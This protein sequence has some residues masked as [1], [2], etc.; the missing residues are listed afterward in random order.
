[1]KKKLLFFISLLFISL[2]FTKNT[3]AYGMSDYINRPLCG[4][5]EVALFKSDGTIETKSCHSTF[6][7]ADAAMIADGN[8]DLA[9]LARFGSETK[10][11][12]AN[13]ALVDLTHPADTFDIY[14]SSSIT[15]AHTYMYGQGGY[16]GAD[17]AFLGTGYSF[18]ANTFTFKIKI[19]GY[20]G[21]V[22]SGIV[23]IVPLVWVNSSSSY[24]ISNETIRHNYVSK[25]QNS[26]SSSSGNTIGPKP[27][28]IP[29]GT[30]YSY[31]G[32]YFY[33]DRYAMI[34]DYKGNTY[35]NSINKDNPY[36][37]YYQ[38]LSNRTRTNYSSINIDEYIRNMGYGRDVYGISA[39]S[40]DGIA[41]SR[42]YGMG[43]FFYNAQER[44]GVN[45]LLALGVSRNETGNGK[46]NLAINKNNGFGLNAVDSSPTES[47]KW[48]ATFS[49]SILGY[50]NKWVNNGYA[51]PTDLRYNGAQYG[52]KAVGMNVQYA[53]DVYWGEKMASNY[54]YMDKALGLQDY[55]YYQLG[56][57]TTSTQAMQQPNYSSKSMYTYK[58][59]DYGV[60]IVGEVEGQEVNG[61]KTW[62]KVV[63]DRNFDNNYNILSLGANYN[64]NAYVYVPAAYILKINEGKNGYITPNEV[65]EYQD[66]D[67]TYDLYI[68]DTVLKPKVAISTKETL[69]YY[70][71]TLLSAK[72]QTLLKNRYVMVFATAYDGTKNPVAYLVTSDYKYNQK[73]WV[74]TDAIKF[75]TCKYGQAHVSVSSGVNT[76]T[77]INPDTVDKLS[78]HFSGL[79]HYNYVPILEE[80]TV[81]NKLWYKVPV[82]LS[83]T[84]R[85]FGWTLADARTADEDVYISAYQYTTANTDPVI[86]ASNQELV[87]GTTFNPKD[88]ATA[89]D[90][91]DGNLTSNIEV[92]TNNVNT[93]IPGQYTVTYKVTDK[94]NSSVTKTI[95]ITII[96]DEEPIITAEDI[97]III[98]TKKDLLENVTASDKEDGT[99]TNITVDDSKV[100]YEAVGEYTITYQVTDK[101]GHIVTKDVKLIIKQTEPPIITASDKTITIGVDFNP[102]EGVTAKSSDQTDLTA[103]IKVIKNTVDT[104][105]KGTYEVT[106]EVTD[107]YNN[108]TTKTIQVTVIDKEAK[109][110]LYYFD[111]LKEESG[112]LQIKGYH[113][114]KGINHQLDEEFNFYIILDN[115]QT[116]TKYRQKMERITDKSEITRPVYSTDGKDYTY[117]WFK[118]NINIDELPDGDYELYIVTENASYYA[119]TKINNKVLKEQ[120]A[121]YTSIKT[122]TTRNNYR[123]SEMPLQFVVR[124][125]KIL[126]KTANS[127]YNQYT[128]F[129][130]LAFENSKL[131]IK[132]TAY[133]IGMD[134]S[135]N[136]VV[137]RK[138]VFEN[139]ETYQTYSYDLDSTTNG[140]YVVGATLKDGL[141]KTRAWFDKSIDITNIPKGAYTIYI[142]TESNVND[143]SEL[144]ELLQ[145]DL[146]D[147][148]LTA[149]GRKYSFIINS[150]SRYRVELLVKEV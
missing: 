135:A 118:G 128:Q 74:S 82:D 133:S 113:A 39:L 148:I 44:Y 19:A 70:D 77:I 114:I 101:F 88:Y 66:K 131:H 137:K 34:K 96:A 139:Q 33:T 75:V 47:A 116:G 99:L 31:D 89:K 8:P 67:Y 61:N 71:A 62:Y 30:Y 18:S 107:K 86:I 117:S 127:V 36:Y 26:S 7:E 25:I 56:V 79:Y 40:N 143:Y 103:T 6:E 140:M 146:S 64:W 29:A 50:A 129:R 110:G 53:S 100:N 63:S 84:T 1:M 49:S 52:N 149:N 16:G 90:N 142:A 122:V 43:T 41:T 124:S 97:T 72:G 83:G 105:K 15:S 21:W 120:V 93:K 12:D 87:E 78:T 73:H 144:E 134:L 81:E 68:E 109:E 55:N 119:Q 17:G 11:L 22:R 58:N 111:S 104:S 125:T 112:K 85:E 141:D 4:N 13:A 138:I 136:Q 46:S 59:A 130:T 38:F 123:D 28:N 80:K 121:E 3:Y 9:V 24:T 14:D 91:E 132:G 2:F 65:T 98:G 20:V 147:V 76:Y 145:R 57:T 23:E 42:L 92:I 54:Y 10:I 108:K 102:K 126:N 32:H 95:T 60:V 51:N 69:Y 106:Y 115:L 37:N 48:Y 5:Y 45:A 150:K 94:N 27:A 35:E